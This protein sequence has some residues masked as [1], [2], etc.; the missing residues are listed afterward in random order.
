MSEDT[1][2]DGTA[3]RER[4]EG[5]AACSQT[6]RAGRAGWAAA[7]TSLAMSLSTERVDQAST[8]HNT[9]SAL[10]V[11]LCTLV[12]PP[13]DHPLSAFQPRRT[14]RKIHVVSPASSANFQPS[15]GTMH[16]CL[17]GTSLIVTG[18]SMCKEL[19]STVKVLAGEL[20]A[21]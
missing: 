12:D 3:T 20:A 1:W 15:R 6:E 7:T 13:R 9:T 19:L 2:M 5:A 16:S 18:R 14:A 17:L 10:G 11:C 4:N 21:F 8:E